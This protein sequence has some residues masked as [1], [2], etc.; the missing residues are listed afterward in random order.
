MNNCSPVQH[1]RPGLPPT[2]MFHGT[3]DEVVPYGTAR[4]FT[5]KM[6]ATGNRCDLHTFKGRPHLFTRN[7]VDRRKC[8]DLA[9]GFLASLGYVKRD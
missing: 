9:D 2:I 4:R 8:L 7:P 1:V 6:Q 3:S 5:E